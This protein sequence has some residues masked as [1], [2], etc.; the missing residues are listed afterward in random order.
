MVGLFAGEDL[1]DEMVWYRAP[2]I[3]GQGK[4]AVYRLFVDTLA[5]A[6]R[7]KLDD[8]GMFPAVRVLGNDTAT[9]LVPAPRGTAQDS[10]SGAPRRSWMPATRPN[11]GWIVAAGLASAWVE[12]GR[13]VIPQENLRLRPNSWRWLVHAS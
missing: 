9:H 8:L 12:R 2:M 4:S 13:G 3:M 11:R 5:Q 6:L 7:M 1:I 10:G